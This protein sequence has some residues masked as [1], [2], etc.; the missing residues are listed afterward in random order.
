MKFLRATFETLPQGLSGDLLKTTPIK[1]T[2]L[3]KSKTNFE[4]ILNFEKS[5][6]LLN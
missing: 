2:K 5:W 6:N 3:E 1:S 4:Q